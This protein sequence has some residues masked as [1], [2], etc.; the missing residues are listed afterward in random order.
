MNNLPKKV[1]IKDIAELAGVSVGTVDRVIHGRSGVSDSSKE[2]VEKILKDL[3]YQPNMYASALASN[4]KYFF[5]CLFPQHNNGDYW[6]AVESG[7]NDAVSTFSDFNINLHIYYYDQYNYSSFQK[8]SERIM[9]SEVDGVIMVPTLPSITKEFVDKLKNK[10]IPFVFIDSNVEELTALAF[11]GQNSVRSGFFAARIAMLLAMNPKK[12]VI[13]R[14][15]NKGLLGSN[16]QEYRERGFR[17]FMKENFSDCEIIDLNLS[18]KDGDLN[19]SILREFFEKN[20][21]IECGITFSS[22]VYIIGEYLL[23]NKRNDFKLI[24]YDLLDRNINCLKKSVV[25]FLIVQQPTLQGYNSVESLCNHLILKKEVKQC[26]YMPITLLNID[27]I[28][29]YLETHKK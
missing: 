26:N 24:G 17:K 3:D 23:K 28:D 8:E 20:K 29:F 21:D 9:K 16:Q 19:K 13:F 1:R 10:K 11:Y 2:K 14:Q 27:N 6:T 7:V 22:K 12:I 25:D 4:K 15:I 5:V 18:A